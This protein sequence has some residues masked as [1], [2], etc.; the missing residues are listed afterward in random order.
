M[1]QYI[2]DTPVSMLD[3]SYWHGSFHIIDDLAPLV[4]MIKTMSLRLSPEA[5]QR[6]AWMDAYREW[7]NAAM[8]CRHFNISRA[9]FYR[10]LKRYEPFNL[11]SLENYSCKPYRSPRRTEANI[12]QAVLQIKREHPRWGKEKLAL[13]L[14]N[15]GR[16]LSSSTVYRILKRHQKILRYRTRKRKPPKPRLNWA[17]IR[18]P[19]DCVQLDV[20]YVTLP[21]GRRFY[22]YTAIDVIT[23]WRFIELFNHRDQNTT[24]R[25]LTVLLQHAPMDI[26]LIQTDNGG[27][28]G[29]QI[30]AWLKEHTITHVFTHKS[31]PVENAYVERSHRTDEEEFYSLTRLPSTLSKARELVKS[32]LHMYN[33]ERPHW[34][35]GGKTPIQALESY[36]ITV[37]D[38]LT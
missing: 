23:R 36:S 20:K 18:L 7:N 17:E 24:M 12:E 29:K 22:Q 26:T 38:V 27:E 13:V 19:G 35:L 8:V 4:S 9:T 34:G 10:W 11:K 1:V 14:N 33:H 28:F 3:K 31:R 32:Y 25:F 30:T 2:R 16:A 37:S 6:L 21:C 5:K 15:Q